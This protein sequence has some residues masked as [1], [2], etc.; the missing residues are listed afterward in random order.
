MRLE[1]EKYRGTKSRYTCP[2]C[3]A[4]HSFVRYKDERGDYI[5]E[6][7]GR[8]NRESKCGYHKKPK[9][10]Y[11]ENPNYLNTEKTEY[12]K[13][14]R[15]NYGF[16]NVRN[17]ERQ[18]VI[19]T[20][21]KL[22]Y[23]PNDALLQTLGDYE[24]NAFVSFLFNLFP[25]DSEEVWQA[26][27]KYFIGTLAHRYGSYTCFPSIDRNRKICR[28]KL[29]RFNEATGKRLK[30]DF[31]TSS[32]PA[33]LKLKE[34]F[35]YKQIFFG[36][37]LLSLEK[38]APVA[39]VEAEKTAVIASIC[40][41]E[42]VWLG[43]NSKT[44]LNAARLEQIGNRQIILYPDADGYARW[45]ETAQEARARG[46][47]VKVSSLIEN[48]ATDEQKQNGYDL[49]DYLVNQQREINEFNNYADEYNARL[50]T[51][52]NDESLREEFNS[53]L[54]EQKAVMID[55]GL[56]ETEADKLLS[57]PAIIRRAV[58]CL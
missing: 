52:L 55:S 54:D 1:L 9:H 31:D 42:F 32:L 19:T 41:P 33:M 26:I 47:K 21:P 18:D 15:P 44:W 45:T 39:V 12:K 40:F 37:H 24:Q 20:E 50:E 30:G 34:G 5:D 27:R 25:E 36:E 10:F 2:S 23:I 53:I 14:A 16:A 28:A 22:D 17:N 43:A 6:S 35:R 51:V 38:S 8:C 48:H 58:M 29:I 49:A 3:G 56:S 11:A 13:N 46:V 4:R 7:V 57:D